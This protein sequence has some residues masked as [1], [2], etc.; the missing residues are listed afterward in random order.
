MRTGTL[1]IGI[2]LGTD[3]I[4]SVIDDG[5]D[6][7]LARA[8][9][10]PYRRSAQCRCCDPRAHRLRQRSVEYLHPTEASIRSATGQV[11]SDV[12]A[13]ARGIAIRTDRFDATRPPATSDA[14]STAYPCIE[15]EF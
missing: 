1:V 2:D 3:S 6:G 9:V 7:L 15:G 10:A 13:R 4:R 12:A 11:G 14:R 5:R 8:A